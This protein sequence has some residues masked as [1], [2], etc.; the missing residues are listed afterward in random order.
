MRHLG[1]VLTASVAL[2]A[3]VSSGH[4]QVTTAVL[5]GT[6][7]DSEGGV[8]PG[9][10]E[11]DIV[12]D[13]TDDANIDVRDASTM[14]TDGPG[15]IDFDDDPVALIRVADGCAPRDVVAGA[16]QHAGQAGDA[17]A[18]RCSSAPGNIRRRRGMSLSPR[19]SARCRERSPRGC[20]IRCGRP[21]CGT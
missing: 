15:G 2:L 14:V 7:S 10:A 5:S 4:A 17:D 16:D 19:S 21:L 9:G 13:F 3:S 8:L 11:F 1:L 6:V 12:R 18:S 20:R